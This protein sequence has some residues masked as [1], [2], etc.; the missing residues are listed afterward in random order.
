[1]ILFVNACGSKAYVEFHELI[2]AWRPLCP[3]CHS[4]SLVLNGGY[5]RLLTV[6]LLPEPAWVYRKSCPGCRQSFTLLP[7]DVLPLHSYGQGIVNQRIL[8][9]L[10]GLPLRSREFYEQKGLVGKRPDNVPEMESSWTDQLDWEPLSPSYQLFQY[11]RG[12]FSRR[13]QLWCRCF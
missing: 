7:D 12:K 10:D 1:L 8:A 9:C 13:A 5:S 11:W 3:Q 6:A 4:R 2:H